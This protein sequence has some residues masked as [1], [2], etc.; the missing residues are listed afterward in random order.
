MTPLEDD[1][2]SRMGE[3]RTLIPQ[4]PIDRSRKWKKAIIITV[5]ILILALGIIIPIIVFAVQ[6]RPKN[7]I[8]MISDGCG[9]ASFSFARQTLGR[10]LK[11]DNILV[12]N[13]QTS[14]SDSLVT[15]SA[16]GAT[17][18]SCGLRSYNGAIGVDPNKK[19]CVRISLNYFAKF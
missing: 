1:N 9:P 3:S 16:A 8:V 14:S 15:D 19:P 6:P 13:I 11:F 2:T 4:P 10:N 18:Y 7:L 5:G 17:A 12:G